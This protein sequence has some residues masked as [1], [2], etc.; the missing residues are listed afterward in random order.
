M[1]DSGIRSQL[2]FFEGLREAYDTAPASTF[3]I[4]FRVSR[5]VIFVSGT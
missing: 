5:A 4:Y 2:G 1:R 3:K